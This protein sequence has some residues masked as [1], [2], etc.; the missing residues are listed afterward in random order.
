M[1]PQVKIVMAA[2]N[3]ASLIVT[4]LF[5][6]DVT[7]LVLLTT[8]ATVVSWAFATHEQT[9]HGRLGIYV[10]TGY[11]SLLAIICIVLGVT[12]SVEQ[13]CPSGNPGYYVFSFDPT[14]AGL[15]KEEFNYLLFAVPFF[16][17]ILFLMGCEIYSA[18]VANGTAKKEEKPIARRIAQQVAKYK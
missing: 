3:I 14:V 6:S 15:G 7:P 18:S 4:L 10:Y 13:P 11:A 16:V 8:I 5:P 2:I 1:S 17:S 9:G 12:A